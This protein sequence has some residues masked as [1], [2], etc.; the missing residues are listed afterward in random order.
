MKIIK[1]V[2]AIIILLSSGS[3]AHAVMNK[4]GVFGVWSIWTGLSK[5]NTPM[6]LA[7]IEN[8]TSEFDIKYTVNG[9]LFIQLHKTG[10][11][12][13]TNTNISMTM[14]IDHAPS[15][16]LRTNAGNDADT[17][18]FVWNMTEINP[19]TSK[20][21]WEEFLEGITH[22]SQIKMAFP[23]GNETMWVGSLNGSTAA[24]NS[25]NLCV[26]HISSA[27]QPFTKN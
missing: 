10:W 13:P 15:L 11:N 5:E 8:A 16:K 24:M 27:T 2:I 20:L 1:Y 25:F 21:Y 23:D 9:G 12:I 17:L 7:T 14:Q 4:T 18:E 6:C 3:V 22:G 19:N 26:L